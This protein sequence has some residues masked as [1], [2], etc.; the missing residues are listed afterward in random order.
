MTRG[1]NKRKIEALIEFARVPRS[2]AELANLRLPGFGKTRQSIFK[3]CRKLKVRRQSRG[4]VCGIDFFSL[5]DWWQADII[6]HFFATQRNKY[7]SRKQIALIFY[8][9]ACADMRFALEWKKREKYLDRVH[10]NIFKIISSCG[11]KRRV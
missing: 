3:K 10:E 9:V 5:P 4:G 1:V 11:E 7:L 6:R 8:S 2:Y